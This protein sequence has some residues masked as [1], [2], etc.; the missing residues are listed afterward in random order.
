MWKR[1]LDIM[2]YKKDD[3]YDFI[4]DLKTC[5]IDTDTKS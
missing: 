3:S 4:D 1:S 2:M 5:D